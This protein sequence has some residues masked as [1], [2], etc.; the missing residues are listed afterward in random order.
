MGPVA[1]KLNADCIHQ[2][3]LA[4]GGWIEIGECKLPFDCDDG[5]LPSNS[6]ITQWTEYAIEGGA[7]SGKAFDITDK[8]WGWLQESGFERTE[9]RVFKY[10][11]QATIL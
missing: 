7:K 9:E 1:V 10:V 4:P 5:S 3:H 11:V 8:V 2:R 6:Y